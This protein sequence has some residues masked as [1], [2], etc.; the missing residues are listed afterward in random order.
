MQ[1]PQEFRIMDPTSISVIILFFNNF[2]LTSTNKIELTITF[3]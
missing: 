1:D 2:I 3:N